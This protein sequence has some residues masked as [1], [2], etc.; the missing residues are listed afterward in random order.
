[1]ANHPLRCAHAP[2]SS[3]G[4]A[5]AAVRRGAAVLAAIGALT[6]ASC[7]KKD[8]AS[9]PSGIP[10]MAANAPAETPLPTPP[11]APQ[12]GPPPGAAEPPPAPEAPV[13]PKAAISGTI[14]LTPARK[15]DVAPADTIFLVARRIA[16]NPSARGSLVAVKRL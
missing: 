5:G 8:D 13:D 4:V 16:D 2:S 3:G 6:L 15:G 7:E 11:P 1:M 10:A 14:V 9:K 12:P